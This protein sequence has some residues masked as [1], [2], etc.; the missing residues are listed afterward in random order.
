MSWN[1][2]DLFA[3]ANLP[4]HVFTHLLITHVFTHWDIQLGVA[5]VRALCALVF[6]KPLRATTGRDDPCVIDLQTNKA[7]GRTLATPFGV[8][9]LSPAN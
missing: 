1:K 6:L 7:R 9:Q 3:C 8:Q 2:F 5:L 4:F